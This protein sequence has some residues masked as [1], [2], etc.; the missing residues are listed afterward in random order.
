MFVLDYYLTKI[1]CTFAEVKLAAKHKRVNKELTG[2]EEPTQN[3][4]RIQI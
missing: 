1:C 3:L 4:I 2:P